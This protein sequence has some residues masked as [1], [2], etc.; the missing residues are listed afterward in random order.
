MYANRD[1]AV[2]FWDKCQA[3]SE[4]LMVRRVCLFLAMICQVKARSCGYKR[5]ESN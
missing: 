5:G 2:T 3:H 1:L 4:V